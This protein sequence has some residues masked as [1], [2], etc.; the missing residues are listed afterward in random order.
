MALMFLYELKWHDVRSF[1]CGI[2]DNVKKLSDLLS[3][4]LEA[5]A[6]EVETGISCC[7]AFPNSPNL[8]LVHIAEVT[9]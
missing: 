3:R 6:N 9:V 4:G 2:R 8:R 5:S 7:S 1:S